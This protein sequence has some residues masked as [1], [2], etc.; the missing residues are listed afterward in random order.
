[1]YGDFDVQ[2]IGGKPDKQMLR[3]AAHAAEYL[4]KHIEQV[5]DIVFGHYQWAAKT[6]GEDTVQELGMPKSVNRNNILSSIPER[7]IMVDRLD[8]DEYLCIISFDIPYDPEHGLR[9]ELEDGEVISVN[10]SEFTLEN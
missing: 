9:L 10:D 3:L 7:G 6:W 1:P 8:D 4:Q 2:L 5:V